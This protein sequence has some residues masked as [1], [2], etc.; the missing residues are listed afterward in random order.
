MIRHVVMFRFKPATT[1]ADVAAIVEGLGGLPH[2]IPE[3]VEYRFGHDIGVNDG[4]FDFVV[5]ADFADTGDYLVYRD[6]PLHQAL[7][8]ERIAPHVEARSAV[9]FDLAR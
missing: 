9:Q 1:A 7:I 8:A 2:A 6:H 4:N 3:I 5:V